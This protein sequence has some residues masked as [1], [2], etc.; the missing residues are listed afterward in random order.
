MKCKINKLGRSGR[1]VIL[2]PKE[3]VLEAGKEYE[4]KIEEWKEP[5][6]KVED[7]VF[8]SPSLYS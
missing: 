1:L 3:V 5:E 2:L 6:K 4:V 8:A 7:E